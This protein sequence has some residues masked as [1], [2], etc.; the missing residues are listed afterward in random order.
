MA[1][2]PNLSVKECLDHLATRLDPIIASRLSGDLG[3]HPWTVVL[4]ILD[5][6]KG[7]ASGY[8][9]WTY[10]LQAQLRMLTER[11]GDF[12]LSVR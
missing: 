7:F 3:G 11:L 6:K 4:D 5:Q 2:K 9:H 1:F 12:R 8:K 10:D